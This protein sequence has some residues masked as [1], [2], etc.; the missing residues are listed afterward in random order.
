MS[1]FCFMADGE[2]VHAAYGYRPK[3]DPRHGLYNESELANAAFY[4][5]LPLFSDVPSTENIQVVHLE[6][7]FGSMLGP[8]RS[9][10]C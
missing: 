7:H 3:Y 10:Q 8:A 6:I 5:T 4:L 9:S 1:G 2:T